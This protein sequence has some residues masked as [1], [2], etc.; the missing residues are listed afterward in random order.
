MRTIPLVT[1]LIVAGW[2]EPLGLDAQTPARDSAS[3]RQGSPRDTL[4]TDSTRT[5]SALTVKLLG[6]LE[7]KADRTKNDR[8]FS[9]Q[10]FT[11]AFRCQGSLTP[12][13]DFQFSLL[14]GGTVGDRVKVNVDYDSQREF[15]GSNA[16]SITY[17][18]KAKEF[19]QR[20]Q[21]G[22]VSF[23]PPAS[24]FITS[25]IPSGNYGVQATAQAGSFRLNAIIAQQ[26]GNVVRDQL[27][28]VGASSR[29]PVDQELE[30]YQIEPRRFFFTL[31][32][33]L[34]GSRYPNIDILDQRQ[35]S[36][37][38]SSLPDTLR[39]SRVSLYRLLIGG[40]PPNPNGPRFSL[41]EDPTSQA[42]QVYELLREG[43]D[44]YIDPSNLWI[45]LVRPLSLTNERLVVA[46]SL[47]IA[48]RDT[49]IAR[50][51]GTP[52]LEFTTAHP[53]F[54]HLL[55]DPRL[56]PSDPVF[57]R[58]IRSV[59]R[60]GG[61]DVDRSTVSV[62]LVS[63]SGGDQET[64]PGLTTTYLQL[65]GL[66]QR[67]SPAAF[68]TANRLWPRPNDPN[69]AIGPT[70]AA[71]ALIKDVFIV[72]PSLEP[73]SRRG[74]ARSPQVVANDTLYRTPAEY[75]YSPQ[76][77]QSAYRFRIHYESNG[78]AGAGTIA[79]SAVQLRP[80]SERL[81]A[82]GRAL[83]RGIDY[84]IDYDLGRIQLLTVDTLTPRLQRVLV[85]YEEN[86]V[87]TSIPTSIMGLTGEWA[88]PFG[89]VALTAL[90]QSQSTTFTRPPLG[91]E[92]QASLMAGASATFGWSLGGLSRALARA[93]PSIDS[94]AHS[95]LDVRAEI[96]VSQP[97]QSA[98]QQAYVEAFEGEG[99]TG[100][101]LLEAQWE[102]SSQPALGNRLAARFGAATFDTLRAATLAFQN[103][104][105]DAT[106]RPVTFTI[107][108]IDPL[109]TFANSSFAGFEQIMWLTLYPLNVG[110]LYDTRLGRY[111][112]LVNGTPMGRRWRSIRTPLGVNGSGIDLTRGEQLEFW[113][114]VDTLLARRTRNPT[115]IFDFG[116][117][118][119]NTV[120]LSPDT[121]RFT[122]VDSL[123]LGKK[124]QGFDVLNSE[125][126][127][128]SRSFS[129]EVNDTG[130]PGDVVD[131]LTVINGASAGS[132]AN[133]RI[134]AIGVGR[135]LNLGDARADCTVRNGRLDE[136]DI[137]QDNVLNFTSAQREQEK[138]RR[139]VVDLSD[140]SSYNRVGVCGP[141]VNDINH[142]APLGAAQCWV[143]VRIPFNAPSDSTNGGPLL[144]RVRALRIT[145]VSGVGL[146][147]NEFTLVPIA[148]LRVLG[149]SLLK[150][151]AR[152][153]AGI[154]GEQQT[155][156][157][158]VSATLIGT[159]D[160]DSTR[161]LIYDPPPGV[162]D[163]PEQQ[164]TTVGLATA[165]IN[166]HSL[167]ILAQDIPKYGRAEAYERFP[168]GQ[169]S[170]M[171]Y[172]ELRLWARGRGNG[173]GTS[174]DLEF[175]VKLGRDA[176]NFYAYR[177]PLNA[178]E[179]RAAWEPEIRVSFERFITL[180]ARLQAAFLQGATGSLG[181]TGVDS[182]LIASS[183]VPQG[184]SG[185]RLAVC[186][187]GYMVYTTDAALTPPNLAAVQELAV[188]IVRVDSLRGANPPLPGDTLE[189]WVDDVR[190]AEVQRATGYAGEV[191]LAFNAGDAGSIRLSAT[192]RDPNFRQLGELPTFYTGNDL[193]VA[194]TWR[195]D[196]L[197]PKRIGLALPLTVTHTA[198]GSDP[199][200]LAGSDV[201]GRGIIGLRTPAGTST[202]V[203][204]G[205][206]RDTPLTDS[207]LAP[208]VNN[209]GLVATWTGAG[210]RNEFAHANSHD[211]NV[212][213]DY[214][215]V[216]T[217]AP[218]GDSA[219]KPAFDLTPRT[220]RISSNLVASNNRVANFALPAAATADT[221]E[222]TRALTRL[223][224]NLGSVEFRPVPD[225]TARWDA[226][227]VRDL[228]HDYRANAAFATTYLTN[229]QLS[230]VDVGLERE[231]TMVAS[232]LYAPSYERWLRPRLELSSSYNMLRDPNAPILVDTTSTGPE[233]RLARRFGNAQRAGLGATI[234]VRRALGQRPPGSLG[235][236]LASVVGPIDV[237]VSR[238]QLTSY[239]ASPLAPS[240]GYQFGFGG[241][242]AFRALR[243]VLAA[244]AGAGT[245]WTASN[246][247]TLPFGAT[248]S[249]R[250]LRSDTRHW[251]RRLTD[252]QSVIDGAQLIYPDISVRWSGHPLFLGALFANIGAT[253]RLSDTWQSFVSPMDIATL[254]AEERSIRIRTMPL[255]LSA[256]TAYGAL[257]FNGAIAHSNRVDSL[258][259]SVGQSQSSDL[260]ADVSKAFALPAAWKKD[261]LLRAR[262]SYQQTETQSYVSNIAAIGAR[263]RLTDNG[264][265]AFSINAGTDLAED[266]SFS[267]QGSRVVTFDRNFNRRFTQ[268][269][270]SVVL[271]IGFFG[272]E[273]R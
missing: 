186:D 251:T 159:Q 140:S 202:N 250:V 66:A 69:D 247:I 155:L 21:L 168:E 213:L 105:T 13:L 54:A 70:P 17:Q 103:N 6:R 63:G 8:C 80:G 36:E 153:I 141:A 93:L 195:L 78:G 204:L 265:H 239:D 223:V 108:Q 42:G 7:F 246:T 37:L 227:T 44:Y 110:G 180:R 2:G 257:N 10:L 260:S 100:I 139:F 25:G 261:R 40:Q 15:D 203:S 224:R 116:D 174:G 143:Q 183:V 106:G 91:F 215:F 181:C 46:Y 221:A 98:S 94:A 60:L 26:K 47:R 57:R 113:V 30:D 144:R 241:V 150:R 104:G 271:N 124:L 82:D 22:N 136:E 179:T 43:T 118:S 163:Q 120:A 152:P 198:S 92:P 170:V 138:L 41:L 52:D 49:T 262:V 171:S 84:D 249:Q 32:P 18:G 114:R 149:S 9:S 255:T 45:A 81:T 205:I 269:V 236:W 64:A 266:V 167:R 173:W 199:T 244:S 29:R 243:D 121:L 193:E 107:Q 252:Q 206:R 219:A 109:T 38:A 268:T 85:R 119:E 77:P 34:F 27:F 248:I 196:K 164:G 228:L 237:S 194:T 166:E 154:G 270:F 210:R 200:F 90:S 65:F 148:R 125:R 4:K 111:R 145:V 126:D 245:Q 55:W 188:G 254:P 87:F 1:V 97:R 128:F 197:L 187:D 220:I 56:E 68:D 212:S 176:N 234:D 146:P 233:L 137:D 62:R 238:D 226:T 132:A 88:L 272:G 157:G 162:T 264:R 130:L 216:G 5:D 263:S 267:L 185:R 28:L 231:R 229:D 192:R 207:W 235:G 158:F 35:M 133:L 99:G 182:A 225:L 73:F 53:Q 273:L 232:A 156:G 89:N 190:L 209:L 19:L 101:S 23:A 51:G 76:H 61:A 16:I 160:R 59:Y 177:T 189:V 217:P 39:P 67:N 72:F 79:L 240:L 112:W 258:P 33:A 222:Q 95:R 259:G 102:Y 115:L 165:A 48:G 122:G 142:S 242:D 14:S 208:L 253:A 191:T 11:A 58:E 83:V 218:I 201:R 24:R 214:L 175:F 117:V 31:D 50:F 211:A 86:P 12:Q 123:Y 74:L 71:G 169:R 75:I 161:G 96:A 151:A 20:V 3:L 127:P 147:D 134:C 178:G 256:T 184:F 135:I 129:A 172:R 131:R 230:A